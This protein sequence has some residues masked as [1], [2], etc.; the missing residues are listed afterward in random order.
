[1]TVI[2]VLFVIYQVTAV[3]WFSDEL[4]LGDFVEAQR[5]QHS[6][7][8]VVGMI[9]KQYFQPTPAYPRTSRI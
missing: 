7:F 8:P 3:G 2:I 1:M 6:R 4:H 5:H 9:Y